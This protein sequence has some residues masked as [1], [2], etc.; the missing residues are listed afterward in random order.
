MPA[1]RLA[2]L[3]MATLNTDLQVYQIGLGNVAT[4]TINVV[5]RGS[6]NAKISLAITDSTTV[7]VADYIN[8]EELVHP[9]EYLYRGG[10][11]LN[12]GQYIYVKTDTGNCSINVWGFEEGA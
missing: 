11:V 10:V 2:K 7:S 5:N 3:E 12:G 6:S 8:F 9:G 1:G 4:V